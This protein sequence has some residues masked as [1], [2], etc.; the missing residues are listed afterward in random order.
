[1]PS[2]L[3]RSP[4]TFEVPERTVHSPMVRARIRGVATKL[5]VDRL[6]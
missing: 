5:I 6:D 3:L 2:I 4:I 1:M